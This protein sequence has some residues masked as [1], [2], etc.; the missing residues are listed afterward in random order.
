MRIAINSDNNNM[1]VEIFHAPYT[2]SK[3]YLPYSINSPVAV[4][5]MLQT[6]DFLKLDDKECDWQIGCLEIQLLLA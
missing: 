2:G 5:G 6:L 3:W 1:S 4:Q